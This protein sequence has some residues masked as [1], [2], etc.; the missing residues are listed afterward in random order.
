MHSTPIGANMQKSFPRIM[1]L[2]EADVMTVRHTIAQRQV[3]N[4]RV[5][6]S[7]LHYSQHR[8]DVSVT[9]AMLRFYN[10]S[11]LGRIFLSALPPS[12][13]NM[14]LVKFA[15]CKAKFSTSVTFPAT[16]STPPRRESHRTP[17]DPAPA[18]P[19][20]RFL[21]VLCCWRRSSTR[22]IADHRSVHRPAA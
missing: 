2:S 13:S 14:N 9:A 22:Q 19:A 10:F 11:W 6:S 5:C 1:T 3:S 20:W 4:W 18:M 15:R 12:K 16:E 7:W 21:S 17:R 8:E